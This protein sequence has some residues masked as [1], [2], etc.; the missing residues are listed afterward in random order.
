MAQAGAYMGVSIDTLWGRFYML[1]D[2]L[3]SMHNTSKRLAES[4]QT[5]PRTIVGVRG[6]A[7]VQHY[8]T[9]A[10]FLMSP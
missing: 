1:P 9:A 2:K 5:T 7:L 10:S 3:E 8:F 4:V 6:K